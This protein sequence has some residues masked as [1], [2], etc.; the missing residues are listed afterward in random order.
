MSNAPVLINNSNQSDKLDVSG[1]AMS[2]TSSYCGGIELLAVIICLGPR[3][4]TRGRTVF[5]SVTELEIA[6]G[7]FVWHSSTTLFWRPL[8]YPFPTHTPYTHTLYNRRNRIPSCSLPV[9]SLSL[10]HRGC[11]SSKCTL[12]FRSHM[13]LSYSF[14]YIIYI[15]RYRTIPHRYAIAN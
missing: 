13:P 15:Y 5:N 9:H 1:V 2:T 11:S 4:H 12:T 7:N 10:F 8:P 14:V 3:T 6:N